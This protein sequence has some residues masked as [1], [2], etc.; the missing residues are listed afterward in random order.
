MAHIP[1]NALAGGWRSV[2]LV[3]SRADDAQVEAQLDAFGGKLG[4]PRAD[5]ASL[6]GEVVAVER[7]PILHEVFEASGRLEAEGMVE[8]AFT[9]IQSSPD[10][11]TATLY[12]SA[13]TTVR[14]RRPISASR[15]AT[16]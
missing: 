11:S 8:A 7:V 1:G 14:G 13:F 10:G 3:D 12:C 16:G 15:Y 2:L 5:L 4:G 6:V 9:P